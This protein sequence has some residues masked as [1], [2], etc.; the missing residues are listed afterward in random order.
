MHASSLVISGIQNN[1]EIEKFVPIIIFINFT[2]HNIIMCVSLHPLSP[3]SRAGPLSVYC[4]RTLQLKNIIILIFNG[5]QLQN[6]ELKGIISKN[7]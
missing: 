1:I 7:S 4:Y 2:K 6:A 5:V 3:T